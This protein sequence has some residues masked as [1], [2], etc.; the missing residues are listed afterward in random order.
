MSSSVAP[1]AP[2]TSELF[3]IP[4]WAANRLLR[5]TEPNCKQPI[6]FLCTSFPPAYPPMYTPGFRRCQLPP[7]FNLLNLSLAV[8]PPG[9]LSCHPL[10]P[11]HPLI[12][13]SCCS[14]PLTSCCSEAALHAEVATS[15]SRPLPWTE[16]LCPLSRHLS[17]QRQ[18]TNK[19]RAAS[20]SA[21]AKQLN[22][23]TPPPPTSTTP[24][25]P[26]T[27]NNP[28]P[29]TTATTATTNN[30]TTITIDT[31]LCQCH[32]HFVGHRAPHKPY[33]LIE[34]GHWLR[35]NSI[36]IFIHQAPLLVTPAAPL[37]NEV[38][39]GCTNPRSPLQP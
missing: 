27:T 30:P 3:R 15:R 7:S 24:P 1:R 29:T 33:A 14:C 12:G 32:C 4:C 31:R 36:P 35:T 2:F 23:T 25:P 19:P 11:L 20:A 10:P 13:T 6:P 34:I 17:Q 8:I 26:T 16:A 37:S 38:W 22:N 18:H 39:F 5:V 9:I 21:R 28:T